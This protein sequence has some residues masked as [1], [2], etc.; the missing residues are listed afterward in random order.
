MYAPDNKPTK[1]EQEKL[2]WLRYG[3]IDDY[4]QRDNFYN[5]YIL[6]EAKNDGR[7]GKRGEQ[8]ELADE[9]D[10]T[11]P[12]VNDNFIGRRDRDRD[13]DR[14]NRVISTKRDYKD[15]FEPEPR[16]LT[17]NDPLA[18]LD[19]TNKYQ[20]ASKFFNS[21][22]AKGGKRRSKKRSRKSKRISKKQSKKRSRNSR[23]KR[24]QRR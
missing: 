1:E 2:Q 14:K 19:S 7:I 22:D 4:K 8:K 15:L 9:K 6:P 17:I 21:D 23:R 18:H 12:I 20:R 24:R 16:I 11:S 3:N 10:S 5:T 13:R